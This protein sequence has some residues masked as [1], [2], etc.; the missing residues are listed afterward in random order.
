MPI[1]NGDTV[2]LHYT[3]RAD[4]AEGEIIEVTTSEE[5]MV[6]VHG[7]DPLL[8]KFLDALV[9]KNQG[10]KV[11]VFISA[12]DAYGEEEESLYVEYPKSTFLVDGELDEE[13]IQE[14]EVIPMNTPDGEVVYG[15]VTEVKL[16]SI[17]L[18]FNHPLAGTDLFFDI[19]IVKV[20]G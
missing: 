12:T 2:T 10:D 20:N 3:L 5:P 16:N 8:P 9:G 6:F 13:A 14:G 4:N 18:D 7:Q 11:Q 17:V 1:S 15:V 19:E